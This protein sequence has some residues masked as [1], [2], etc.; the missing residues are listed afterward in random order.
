VS[1]T[2][3]AEVPSLGNIT[4]SVYGSN[5]VPYSFSESVNLLKN[6]PKSPCGL[7]P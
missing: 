5:S 7:T 1:S 2:P 3:S 6:S 4:E